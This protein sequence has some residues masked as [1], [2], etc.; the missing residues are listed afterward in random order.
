MILNVSTT[1]AA[2]EPNIATA[3]IAAASVP[4]SLQSTKVLCIT[5]ET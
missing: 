1:G 2:A 5:S 4:V 3:V